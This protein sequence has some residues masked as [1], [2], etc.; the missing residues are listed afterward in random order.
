MTLPGAPVAARP[1]P[2][3]GP[4]STLAAPA[5]LRFDLG[6]VLVAFVV[7][8]S[9]NSAVLLIDGRI[10]SIGLLGVLVLIW[11]FRPVRIDRRSTFM[12]V[13]FVG[14]VGVHVALFGTMVVPA[15]LGVMIKVL[16]AL[17]IVRLVPGFAGKLVT[18]MTWAALTSFVFFVPETLGLDL[19]VLLAP[20][21]APLEHPDTVHVLL[22]NFHREGA[23]RNSGMFW[24]PGAFAGYL[25]MTL[26]LIA[27]GA[28]G[29]VPRWKTVVL[30]V[31][32]VSTQST[33]GYVAALALM[34][35]WI[36]KS[37]DTR[38][39]TLRY[40]IAPVLL[41]STVGVA[42][43]GFTQAPFLYEKVE[44]QV[45]EAI[46]GATGAEINRF[47]NFVYD[48]G[49]IVQRP[50]TGWSATPATRSVVDSEVGDFVVHQGNGLTGFTV[51]FGLLGLG[52]YLLCVYRMLSASAHGRRIA[53]FGVVIICL[54][55]FGEQF[56]NFPL[57]WC[58]A[59]LPA[60]GRATRPARATRS[61][62]ARAAAGPAP[63]R[64]AAAVP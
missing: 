22:H 11:F 27:G 55:L 24:E 21:R 15:S 60:P 6:L 8:L 63:G 7:L 33:T 42:A 14:L 30:A 59:F 34:V 43:I 17:L 9:G 28:A 52:A 3:Q 16:T 36:M 56:Q 51:R 12:I 19:K 53:V 61:A 18:V 26:L 57:F 32:L 25:V 31:A 13:A 47:G 23:G 40:V 45:E 10:T 44:H 35:H 37:A 49:F 58:L 29:R 62:G 50:L 2:G 46:S 5:R 1:G 4:A 64:I 20:L 41:V 54:I 39:S 48:L 38:L